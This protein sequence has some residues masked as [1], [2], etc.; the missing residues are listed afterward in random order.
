V[1]VNPK[2]GPS[3]AWY[4]CL[5]VQTVV[6]DLV[7]HVCTYSCQEAGVGVDEIRATD[8]PEGS[9]ALEVHGL[10]PLLAQLLTLEAEHLGM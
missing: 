7:S 3:K 9:E 1:E 2:P 4:V 5:P 8:L 10:L 6:E